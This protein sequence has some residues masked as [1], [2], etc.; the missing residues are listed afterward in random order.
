MFLEEENT[1]QSDKFYSNMGRMIG[2]KLLS[3]INEDDLLLEK[4]TDREF[5]DLIGS[6]N[7]EK[8]EIFSIEIP[9]ETSDGAGYT[10]LEQDIPIDTSMLRDYL[11]E[12]AKAVVEDSELKETYRKMAFWYDDFNK[13]IFS[14][15]S[16]SDACLLLAATAFCSA[17]TALDVNIIEA[18]KLF[19]AVKMDYNRGNA[20]K[21][22]LRYIATNVSSIDKQKYIDI[23]T[24]LGEARSSY[25]QLLK[26]KLDPNLDPSAVDYRFREITVSGAKLKNFND[27]IIYYLDHNAKVTKKELVAD[28]KSGRLPIGG[29]KV[30]SFLINLIDP[31]FEWVNLESTDFKQGR[32]QPATVDRWMIRMFF[33]RPLKILVD[34]LIK[35]KTISKDEKKIETFK[36]EVVASLFSSDLVRGN[37]IKLMNAILQEYLAKYPNFELK[38]TH[39]LQAF[40]WVKLRQEY[41]MPTA[42]FSSFEDVVNF[43]KKV[44]DRIDQINPQLN[45]INKTGNET[46]NSVLTAIRLLSNIPRPK[47]KDIEKTEKSIQNWLKYG[48]TP[49]ITK[50]AKQLIK[51]KITSTVITKPIKVDG[52]YQVEIQYKNK[53]IKKIVAANSSLAIAS[54]KKWIRDNPKLSVST[55]IDKQKVVPNKKV[56]K[57]TQ[58]DYTKQMIESLE[59]E[60][61]KFLTEYFKK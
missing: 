39:Q 6:K 14:N 53:T 15:L 59:G 42:T 45:F 28:I 54:A 24:G 41:D 49:D 50:T 2:S 43:S 30:Y 58:E 47:L 35:K 8:Q 21:N 60:V 3:E 22:L 34:K 23:L 20:G 40:G 9:I 52:V 46:K 51:G 13:L 4:Q 55:P 17:N 27:F 37:I 32:I 61:D 26:P 38:Y 48:T 10:T 29:T 11:D 19:R 1:K 7:F 33:D 57:V 36:T 5:Y 31:E 16:E 56:K 12:Y 18:T 44:S 25:L